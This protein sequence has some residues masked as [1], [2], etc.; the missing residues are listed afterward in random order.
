MNEFESF[1]DLTLGLVTDEEVWSYIEDLVSNGSI[2][3]EQ[4]A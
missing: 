4:I 1:V 2:T 3:A